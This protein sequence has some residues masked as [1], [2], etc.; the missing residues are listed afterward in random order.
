[1]QGGLS[2]LREDDEEERNGEG[3]IHLIKEMSLQVNYW[4]IG[5]HL[6]RLKKLGRG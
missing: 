2:S 1:M 4:F 3:I 6:G 5:E